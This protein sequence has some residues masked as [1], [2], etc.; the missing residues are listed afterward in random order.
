MSRFLLERDGAKVKVMIGNDL[1][2]ETATELRELLCAVL[3]DGGIDLTLDLSGMTL[4]DAT[5][6]ALLIATANS[7][8]GSDKHLTL[9]SVPRGIFSLLESL[10]I[11]Q[12]LG[13]R[14]GDA[15]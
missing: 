12:H 9:L 5:G 3:E 14:L 10:R 2:A 6:I 8:H 11:A 7:Y 15:L 1:S 4:L 13:G